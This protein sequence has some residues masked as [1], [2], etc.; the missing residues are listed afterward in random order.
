MDF[1]FLKQKLSNFGSKAL[2]AE[3]HLRAYKSMLTTQALKTLNFVRSDRFFLPK[4]R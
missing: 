4:Q 1:N 3:W 2:V